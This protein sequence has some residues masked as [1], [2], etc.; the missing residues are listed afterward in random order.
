MSITY[1]GTSISS[2]DYRIIKLSHESSPENVLNY[3]KPARQDGVVI[4][5]DNYGI[6]NI[7]LRGI[8][9]GD[10]AADLEANIDTLK[11]LVALKDKNLDIS[12]AGS[13]RRYVCRLK[14]INI[15]RNFYHLNFAPFVITFEVATGYG[16]D[17]AATNILNLTG[18]TAI[19]GT[20]STQALTFAGSYSPKP[21]HK[22][23]LNTRGNA[24][25]V[26]VENTDTGDYMEVDLLSADGSYAG[27]VDGDYF[28]I[29]E[30]NQTVK[31]NGT[32]NLDYRGKFPSVA[33]GLNNIK[34]TVY[35]ANSTLDTTIPYSGTS[36]AKFVNSGWT[37][38]PRGY[39]SFVP[40]MSG[41]VRFIRPYVAKYQIG[42]LGGELRF[43]LRKDDNG[44]PGVYVDNG[45][46]KH[47]IAYAAIADS[48]LE[49]AYTTFSSTDDNR[50][51]LVKGQK[52]WVELSQAGISGGDSFNYYVWAASDEPSDYLYGKSMFYVTSY[53]D[54]YADAGQAGGGVA[55]QYDMSM[56]LYFG[57]DGGAA[58][59]NIDWR[60]DYVKKYI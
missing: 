37:S 40:T 55:G 56:K 6:K 11:A 44:K 29:D 17:T 36:L 14:I 31:K 42:D 38:V 59:H 33:N 1:N 5:S 35:G 52:Y 27:L 22:V 3:L 19:T 18:A 9:L 30:E 41:R 54:G 46:Y 28:E 48:N 58:N 23:T 45:T 12:Y 53:I 24:D 25:V 26:K 39:Q 2:G 32:T 34:L 15:D 43:Y 13:T 49:E 50:P 47:T 8:A 57:S 51:F 20:T 10:D 7:E 21:I 4:I 60:I 16:E